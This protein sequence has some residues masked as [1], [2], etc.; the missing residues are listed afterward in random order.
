MVP[1]DSCSWRY[2]RS[3]DLNN[4]LDCPVRNPSSRLRIALTAGDLLLHL[5]ALWGGRSEPTAAIASGY[6]ISWPLG[7]GFTPLAER[8]IDCSIVAKYSRDI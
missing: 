8:V 1:R 7:F 6:P 2:K 4:T 3:M 5:L